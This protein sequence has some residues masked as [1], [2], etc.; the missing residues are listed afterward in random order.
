M[1]DDRCL[2]KRNADPLIII[3][4]THY[5]PPLTDKLLTGRELER[6]DPCSGKSCPCFLFLP[7]RVKS[8]L[9]H[10]DAGPNDAS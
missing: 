9:L 8:R 10:E 4:A 6:V 2:D 7:Y 5:G 1:I 3:V